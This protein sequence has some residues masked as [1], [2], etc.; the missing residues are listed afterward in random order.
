MNT[1]DK[2]IQTEKT[3]HPKPLKEYQTPELIHYGGISSLVR[4]TVTSGA[5]GGTFPTSAT[6]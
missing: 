1:D 5:D 2:I 6:S 3:E 4:M